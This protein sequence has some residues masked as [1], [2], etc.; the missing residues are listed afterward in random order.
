MCHFD[1]I[2]IT[3]KRMTDCCSGHLDAARTARDAAVR[4][5][6]LV[7][8]TEQL[9]SPGVRERVIGEVG[10]I[11]DGHVIFGEDGLEVPLTPIETGMIR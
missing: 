4:T 1:N 10:Q 7:H 9:E 11:F 3:D 2:A 8:I 5:L 6:V